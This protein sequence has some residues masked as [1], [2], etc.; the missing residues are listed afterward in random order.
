[1]TRSWAMFAGRSA[2]LGRI[3]MRPASSDGVTVCPRL[4]RWL[5]AIGG[6]VGPTG[7]VFQVLHG[8]TAHYGGFQRQHHTE[9][10][11][12]TPNAVEGGGALLDKPLAGAVDS[13]QAL[14]LQ[15][16]DGHKASKLTR[17]VVGTG[18]REAE[19]R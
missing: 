6:G 17:P 16:L 8:L 15:G 10:G 9:L 13:Q 7:Q 3:A 2:W 18:A 1:M 5:K 11:Q 12:K 19:R 14:L 4:G